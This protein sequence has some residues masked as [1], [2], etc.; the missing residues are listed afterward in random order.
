ML[1]FIQ[2]AGLINE[3]FD[4]DCAPESRIA[5]LEELLQREDR[6]IHV[7]RPMRVRLVYSCTSKSGGKNAYIGTNSWRGAALAAFIA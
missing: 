5:K 1:F 4:K 3:L 7:P 6:I 2:Q